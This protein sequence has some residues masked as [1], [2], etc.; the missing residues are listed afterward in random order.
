MTKRTGILARVSLDPD[1]DSESPD[2]Q[3]GDAETLATQRGWQ[4][5]ARYVER[6]VSGYKRNVKRPEYDRLIADMRADKLDVV[7][8]WAVDRLTRQGVVGISKFLNVMEETGVELVSVTQPFIDSTTPIGRGVLAMIA[9]LAEQESANISIRVRRAQRYA[10]KNGQAH[11]GGRRKFGRHLNGTIN[12]VEAEIVRDVVKRLIAGE[13]FRSIATSLNEACVG[14]GTGSRWS[15]TSVAGMVKA[16]HL[17]GLRIVEGQEVQTNAVPIIDVETRHALLSALARPARDRTNDQ[18]KL[19]AGVVRCAECGVTMKH[20]RHT[21]GFP[22]Y[23]CVRGPGSDAC[24]RVAV[25]LNGV[26]RHV[27]RKMLDML[28]LCEIRPL[29]GEDDEPE[30]EQQLAEAKIAVSDLMRER[31]VR[32]TIS[33][34]DFTPLRNE[35]GAEVD[36][37]ESRLD[38]LRRGREQR[39]LTLPLGDRDALER[40][41]QAA[42]DTERHTTVRWA[43]SVVSV[44]PTAKRGSQFDTDRVHVEP[45]WSMLRWRHLLTAADKAT[46]G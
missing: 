3:V 7:V 30:L 41:W 13:S 8:V 31:F 33:D 26:E 43:L 11:T 9:S 38:A 16:P 17:A 29:E 23:V 42:D 32:R 2:Q 6:D 19:L 35:L 34:A 22:R 40:W 1:G 44:S 27:V 37:L 24:G 39:T 21:N 5:V 28:A 45:N 46:P 10:A 20:L 18:P 15:H 25:T 12:E 36:R 4:V 14:T